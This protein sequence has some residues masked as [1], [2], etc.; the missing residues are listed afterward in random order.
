MH[1]HT[2]D[3]LALTKHPRPTAKRTD[4]SS[5]HHKKTKQNK[6]SP[7]REQKKDVP[8]VSVPR[9]NRLNSRR[10]FRKGARREE[11]T[12]QQLNAHWSLPS[13]LHRSRLFAEIKSKK[14]V[15]CR[16]RHPAARKRLPRSL[17]SCFHGAAPAEA[18]QGERRGHNQPWFCIDV[19]R[20]SGGRKW[21]GLSG[22]C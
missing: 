16:S 2:Q 20:W 14:R 8:P 18:G 9:P 6:D 17:S 15:S 19:Q 13:G 1:V 5:K 3:T 7:R 11:E 12:Q 21:G 10:L 4:T 22:L